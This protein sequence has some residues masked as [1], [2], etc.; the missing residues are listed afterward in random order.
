MNQQE[1][2]I[3]KRAPVM[4]NILVFVA[5]VI[6][7]SM[8]VVA[9]TQMNVAVIKIAVFRVLALIC[10]VLHCLDVSVIVILVGLVLVAIKVSEMLSMQRNF[11]LYSPY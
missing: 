9:N 10:K 8:E 7:I 4:E 11:P 6:R 1:R 2:N 3:V 5:N